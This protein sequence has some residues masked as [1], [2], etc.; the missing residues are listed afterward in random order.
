MY[1]CPSVSNGNDSRTLWEYQNPLMFKSLIKWHSILHITHRHSSNTMWMQCKLF[2]Y[3]LGNNHKKTFC[4]CSVPMKFYLFIY[5]FVCLF[6]YQ[7]S[8]GWIHGCSTCGCGGLTITTVY[9]FLILSQ[10]SIRWLFTIFTFIKLLVQCYILTYNIN[11]PTCF[12]AL[13]PNR[14]FCN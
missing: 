11:F 5:S 6:S 9:L 1:S 3:C 2:L 8:V 10:F 12:Q 4:A 13:F 7:S 14:S